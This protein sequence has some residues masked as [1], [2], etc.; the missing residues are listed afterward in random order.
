MMSSRELLYSP[1][2]APVTLRLFLG[3]VTTEDFENESYVLS[4]TFKYAVVDTDSSCEEFNDCNA[5]Q[6]STAKSQLIEL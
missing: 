3:H 6:G 5:P 2:L 4:D 1:T